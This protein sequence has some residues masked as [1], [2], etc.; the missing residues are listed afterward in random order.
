MFYAVV[1][2]NVLVSAMMMVNRYT[3]S[4]IKVVSYIFNGTLKPIYNEEIMTEYENV[5]HRKKFNFPEE[6][7]A[8]ILNRI[9]AVGITCEAI[10]SG[11]IFI[12]RKDVVFFEVTYAYNQ[13][14]AENAYLITGNIKHFPFKPFVVTPAQFVSIVEGNEF[15]E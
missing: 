5:L 2:T 4:P 9:K 11:E 12:D 10:E 8:A 15:P 1:D 13:A 3:S 14:N 6:R 7:I